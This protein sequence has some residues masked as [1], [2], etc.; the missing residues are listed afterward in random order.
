MGRGLRVREMTLEEIAVIQRLARSR[1]E[2]QPTVERGRI[3]FLS[4]EGRSVPSIA[5][6]VGMCQA[7][8]RTWIKR[9]NE[10]GVKGLEDEPRS[11][12][13]ARYTAEEVGQVIAASLSKPADLGLP[14]SSWTLDCLEAYLN[15]QKGIAMKRS[16]IGEVLLAEGL[17]WR[18]QETW[19]GERVDPE[20]SEKRGRS[21]RST[22]SRLRAV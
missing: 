17:R 10:K 13:P 5:K 22:P 14:F 9:Y 2:A 7:M 21:R 1:T 12:R 4:M 11:G 15:E 18:S 20:F 16:R 19:F 3:M 6:E 8:V